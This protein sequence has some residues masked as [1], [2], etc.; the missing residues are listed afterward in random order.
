VRDFSPADN[1]DPREVDA[2]NAMIRDL[3]NQEPA[4]RPD[5]E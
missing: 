1:G 3:R 5:T 2:F 4:V